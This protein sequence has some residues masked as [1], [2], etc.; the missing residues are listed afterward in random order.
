M[1]E[2][3]TIAGAIVVAVILGVLVLQFVVVKGIHAAVEKLDRFY[4]GVDVEIETIRFNIFTGRLEL[5]KTIV[6]NPKGFSGK[7]LLKAER[8]VFDINTCR[9]FCSFGMKLEIEELTVQGI[10]IDVEFDGHLW[11]TSNV[12]TLVGHMNEAMSAKSD[13]MPVYDFW[14]AGNGDHTFHVLPAWAREEIGK[15]QFY[16]YTRQVPGTE[17]VYD[18]FH[19]ITREH[20]FHMGEPWLGE[21]KGKVQFYACK[22]A[23]EGTM[24]VYDFYHPGNKEHTFHFLPAWDREETG[25]VQFH[26]YGSDPTGVSTAMLRSVMDKKAPAV[27]PVYAFWHAR[28][29]QHTFHCLPAWGGET[30]GTIQFYAYDQAYRGTVPLYDFWHSAGRKHFHIGEA[31][32]GEE[33]QSA[34]FY[35]FPKKVRGTEPVYEFAHSGNAETNIHLGVPWDREVRGDL[36]FYAYAEDPTEIKYFLK[37]VTLEGIRAHS[38]T[39]HLE[40]DVALDDVRFGDFSW[41]F[42]AYTMDK[43]TKHLSAELFK[44]V[45]LSVPLP[46]GLPDVT[47]I[48]PKKLKQLKC[49]G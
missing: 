43:I 6:Y 11:D 7:Y 5:R 42:N 19:P 30:T 3:C 23:L 38:A 37:K 2:Y 13:V 45:S 9:A 21:L 49:C 26:A 16:A 36:H 10:E 40:A 17:P 39:T 44:K 15:V 27:K 47:L 28:L 4:L 29:K 14:H 24:P 25:A 41:Q 46:R 8:F 34:L 20:T 32:E 12:M 1:V 35:V 22:E 31:R 18:F 48:I 33:R